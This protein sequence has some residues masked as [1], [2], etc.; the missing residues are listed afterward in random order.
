MRVGPA[1][2][3]RERVLTG[4][5]TDV[6]RELRP[7]VPGFEIVVPD[8]PRLE[9]GWVEPVREAAPRV[10]PT[11]AAVAGEPAPHGG[12]AI[13]EHQHLWLFPQQSLVDDVCHLDRKRTRLKSTH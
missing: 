8:R 7:L 11:D 5:A 3:T 1:M 6:E 12:R 9:V 13:V 4:D 2:R 10:R